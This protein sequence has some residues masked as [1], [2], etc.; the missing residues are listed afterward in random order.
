MVEGSILVV[1][2][3]NRM[4]LDVIICPERLPSVLSSERDELR[5][6]DIREGRSNR[7]N[8]SRGGLEISAE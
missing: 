3:V 7:N 5:S 8:S 2:D 4:M 6:R 1:V